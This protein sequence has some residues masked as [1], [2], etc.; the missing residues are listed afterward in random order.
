MDI[1]LLMVA[2]ICFLAIV[3]AAYP[4]VGLVAVVWSSFHWLGV[5]AAVVIGLVWVRFCGPIN[6]PWSRK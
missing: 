2:A 5:Y 3:C 4:L 1:Q 6:L